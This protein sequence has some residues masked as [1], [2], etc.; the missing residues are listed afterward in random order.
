MIELSSKWYAVYT[1][2]RWE[3]KV[4]Q[5]L[6]KKDIENYCPLNKEE[7]QWSDR[8]K[9]VEVPL[10]TSYVFVK[11]NQQQKNTVLET[12][13]ILNFVYWI[14]KPA[15]IRDEEIETIKKFLN[16]YKQVRLEK[17]FVSVNDRVKITEGPLMFKEG[18]VLDVLKNTVKVQLPS[19]GYAL[20]VSIDKQHVE[21]ILTITNANLL[22]LQ[23]PSFN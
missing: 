19:L 15:V 3:K 13:G 9:I 21:R 22:K 20:V 16:D 10:F 6:S 1:K 5:L 23:Q 7:H 2:P 17:T 8:K 4:S 14:G 12:G 18:K 11:I